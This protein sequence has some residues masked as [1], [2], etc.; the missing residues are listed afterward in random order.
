[1]DDNKDFFNNLF[2]DDFFKNHMENMEFGDFLDTN[3]DIDY[4]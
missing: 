2:N 3:G 1:M 4:E